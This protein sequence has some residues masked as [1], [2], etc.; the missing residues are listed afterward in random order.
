MD[1][2][3]L[4]GIIAQEWGFSDHMVYMIKNHHLANEASRND[5]ATACIYLADMVAMIVDTGLGVDRLAYHVYQDVF[6][7]FF[8]DRA[9]VRAMLSNYKTYRRQVAE[10]M[11]AD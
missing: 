4:G 10:F 7:E 2:S 1:H 3:A 6:N 9:A 8:A 11:A 5:P